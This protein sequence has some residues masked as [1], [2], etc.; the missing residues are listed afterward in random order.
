MLFER[1]EIHKNG[2]A[3][4]SLR[5]PLPNGLPHRTPF[6]ILDVSAATVLV[7]D[8]DGREWTL[9]TTQVDAGHGYHLDGE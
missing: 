1:P 9:C 8:G 6:T 2:W 5:Y 7:R 4:D 3:I